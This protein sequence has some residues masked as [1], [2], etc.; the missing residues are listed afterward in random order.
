MLN[1][2]TPGYKLKINLLQGREVMNLITPEGKELNGFR[3]GVPDAYQSYTLSD[4]AIEKIVTDYF[5]GFLR[6]ASDKE[7]D[8]NLE[9]KKCVENIVPFI[10]N[11]VINNIDL[12][13]RPYVE[14][15]DLVVCFYYILKTDTNLDYVR[16]INIDDNMMKRLD[17]KYVELLNTANN[18][19]NRIFKPL[20][21]DMEIPLI[22]RHNIKVKH[23]TTTCGS[24]GSTYLYTKTLLQNIA[25]EYNESI[26]ILPWTVDAL[27]IIPQSEVKNNMEDIKDLFILNNQFLLQEQS[28]SKIFYLSD[29]IYKLN[30]KNGHINILT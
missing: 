26:Y 22:S 15:L 9:P 2:Y 12:F 3:L 30:V 10:S 5:I 16:F 24:Y 14:Y 23:L 17:I 4:Y 25:K 27:T 6:H 19:Y 11:K 1:K 18:N 13:N 7:E 21:E 28:G 8:L 20:I 29:N